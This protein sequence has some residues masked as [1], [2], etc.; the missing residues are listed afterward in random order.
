MIELPD[1]PL[2]GDSGRQRVEEDYEQLRDGLPPDRRAQLTERH[3]VD[4]AGEY[5]GREIRNPCG[6]ASGQLSLNARQVRRDADAQL[7]FVVLK[8]VI[9]EDA[10]GGQSMA[11]WAIPETHMRVERIT[12]P[13]GQQGWTGT[14]KG[15]GWSDTLAAYCDLVRQ[16]AAIGDGAG[17]P[18]APSVK[19]HLPG[20]GEGEFRVGEYQHTTA[21]LQAAWREG[22][23]TPMPLEK[24]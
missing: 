17:M 14:W 22:R 7:G 6:K 1:T 15:R 16:A 18:V 10:G 4:V 11:A 20:P 12:A 5:A 21:L 3:G 24:D 13:G 19:Y 23:D 9:A 2:L 8:T